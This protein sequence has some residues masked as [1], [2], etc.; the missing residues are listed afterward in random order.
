MCVGKSL[1]QKKD[2][3]ILEGSPLNLHIKTLLSYLP[4]IS[5]ENG[6]NVELDIDN[7]YNIAGR[8]FTLELPVK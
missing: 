3:T 5:E 8:S 1:H 6:R 2:L 4:I 7:A